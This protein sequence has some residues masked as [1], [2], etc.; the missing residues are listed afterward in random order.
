[1][2]PKT[3]GKNTATREY[4]TPSETIDTASN[5]DI[6]WPDDTTSSASKASK[7]KDVAKDEGE[8][9][10]GNETPSP[11]PSGVVLNADFRD[12]GR[13]AEE[14]RSMMDEGVGDKER[15]G[16]LE[17]LKAELEEGREVGEGEGGDKEKGKGKHKGKKREGE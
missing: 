4:Y 1:M 8:G 10:E 13:L 5:E 16:R 6:E 7:G 17:R 3:P 12:V 11:T 14:N 2:P 15:K 9:D